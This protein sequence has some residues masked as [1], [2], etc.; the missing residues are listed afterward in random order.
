MTSTSS[1]T[2][3]PSSSST[4]TCSAC[5]C[6][7]TVPEAEENYWKCDSCCKI[8]LIDGLD[9]LMNKPESGDPNSES[10][11]KAEQK[12]KAKHEQNERVGEWL[13]QSEPVGF[14]DDEPEYRENGCF[15]WVLLWKRC[16][17]F[18]KRRGKDK[19]E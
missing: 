6:T 16:E 15:C 8:Y 1:S 18:I 9:K 17:G 4:W 12:R 11:S 13:A 10:R 2:L 14:P 3:C 7:N 5:T 19:P